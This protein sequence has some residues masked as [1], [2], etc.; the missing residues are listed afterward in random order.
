MTTDSET[1]P[2]L[3]TAGPPGSGSLN[4]RFPPEYREEVQAL[5]DENGIE[6]SMAAEFS[7]GPELAIEAVQLFGGALGGGGIAVALTSFY[8]TFVH[9][10]D[11]KSVSI[12]KDGDITVQGFSRK[13]T[14]QI[15]AKQ[16]A[17]QEQRDADWER[18]IGSDSPDQ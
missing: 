9:R 12:T 14:E 11:N 18:L 17:D 15:I 4:L 6:H 16:V 10:H 3:L 1:I 2:L 8:K 13:Q 7:S 5:L